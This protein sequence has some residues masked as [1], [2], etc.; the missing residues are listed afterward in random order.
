MRSIVQLIVVFLFCMSSAAMAE[1]KY[2]GFAMGFAA[3]DQ[4]CDYWDSGCE[5]D[6][7]SF[8]MFGGYKFNPNFA[9]ELAYHDTGN[10]KDKDD[11]L[12]KT[13]ESEGINFSILALIPLGSEFELYAKM[14]HMI[15]ET[16][17]TSSASTE[18]SREDES[19]MTFGAG[20]LWEFESVDD[21]RY[22]LR[23]E[24]EKLQELDDQFI[25]GGTNLTAWSFGG[26][27]L[28]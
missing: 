19:N 4:E 15:H 20:L 5:G 11:S 24:F 28:F 17:Y 13:A 16:K 26:A 8:K 27:L 12:T 22:Q 14:G 10:I 3:A 21:R 1:D 7:I 9:L 2:V 18:T 25:S 23:F 6:D